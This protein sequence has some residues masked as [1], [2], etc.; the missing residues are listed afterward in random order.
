MRIRVKEKRQRIIT[1]LLFTIFPLAGAVI[2]GWCKG[3]NLG[4]VFLPASYWNDELMYYKQVEG[5]VAYGHPI[6]WFG[7][8][9]AHGSVYPYAAWSPVILLPWVIWGKLFGWNL[10]SPVYANLFFCMAAMGGFAFLAKPNKKQSAC[11]LVLLAAFVP[12]SRYILSGMPESLCMALGILFAGLAFSWFQKEHK[13]KLAGMFLIA[14]FLMLSRPYLGLFFLLPG[15]FAWKKYRFKGAA[16]SL[17]VIAVT[18]GA[19]LWVTKKSCSAY[20]EPIVETEWLS[21]FGTEGFGAGIS[22]IFRTLFQTFSRLFTYYLKD[23]VRYGLFSGALYGVTGSIAFLLGIRY[24]YSL[25]KK[26]EKPE[27]V[28]YLFQFLITAAMILALFLFYRMGE[29][30]KHLMIFIATGLVWIGMTEKKAWFL[31]GLTAVLCLYFFVIKAS[32]PYDW[33]VA[34]GTK[35]LHEEAKELETQLDEKLLPAVNE[36]KRAQNRYENTVIWLAS[37][38]VNGESIPAAWGLLYMVPEGFGINFCTQAYVVEQIDRLQSAYIA[39]LPDGEVEKLLIQRG[40][41]KLAGTEHM[42]VYCLP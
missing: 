6:G 35:E 31:Q 12:F 4:D 13:G 1:I 7:F 27:R 34:Y 25:C 5:I 22:Y 8:N 16:A 17:A 37:D 29:G 26:Q 21:L 41:E 36:K 39:L 40:A 11:V 14:A 32:A 18:T 3:G 38:I 23:G 28:I 33:Q 42:A 10:T 9:E 30:S 24:V 20:I 19:Y 15:Y 2:Y